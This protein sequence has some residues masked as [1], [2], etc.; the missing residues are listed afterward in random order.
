VNPSAEGGIDELRG[1]RPRR[2][3]KSASFD[4]SIATWA[5]SNAFPDTTCS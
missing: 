4:S 2:S 1:L 5:R 3:S